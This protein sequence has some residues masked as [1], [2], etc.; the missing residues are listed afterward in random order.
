MT[1][2]FELHFDSNAMARTAARLGMKNLIPLDQYR[3][4]DVCYIPEHYE[5]YACTSVE[6]TEPRQK[7]AYKHFNCKRCGAV[8]QIDVCE[9]CGYVYEE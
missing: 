4:V 8:N 2:G 6:L 7:L 3:S 5:P 9:Y 1:D